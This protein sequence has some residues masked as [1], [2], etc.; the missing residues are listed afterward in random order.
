MLGKLNSMRRSHGAVVGIMSRTCQH[1]LGVQVIAEGWQTSVQLTYEAVR[2]LTFLQSK[3]EQLNGQHILSQ[4]ARSKVYVL[5]ETDRLVSLVQSTEEMLDNLYV[6]DASDTHVYIY[7]ADGQFQLVREFHFSEEESSASSGYRELLAVHK[8]LQSDPASFAGHA[9]GLVFWKT[10]SKNCYSFLSKGSRLPDVQRL[11]VD[12]KCMERKLD[13]RLVP[14]WTPR[15]H[16]RIVAADLGSKLNTNTDEWCIDRTDLA[17]VFRKLDYHPEV[18]CMATRTNAICPRFFSKIPQVGTEGVNFLA[19]ELHEN[20]MYYCCPPVK[21]IGRVTCH[22]LDK[23]NVNCLLIVPVW[24][25]AAYWVALQ[26]SARFQETI[27]Q[28]LCFRPKF[29]YV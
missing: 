28:K 26:E 27:V 14:V 10:D 3:L 5:K 4:E 8:T 16:A 7:K 6:S 13:I 19:Q 1:L 9:G 21:M 2:E 11:V 12:I 24:H 18:D 17:K 22:L 20:T 15:S 29:F 25:S 23:D